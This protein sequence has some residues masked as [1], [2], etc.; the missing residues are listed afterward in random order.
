MIYAGVDNGPAIGLV[1]L[2]TAYFAT[3]LVIWIS[4]LWQRFKPK[5]SLDRHL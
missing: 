5:Q 4:Y 3:L 1:A 2:A